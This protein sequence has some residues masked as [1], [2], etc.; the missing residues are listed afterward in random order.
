MRTSTITRRTAET[1]IR[2]TLDID[3]TGKSNHAYHIVNQRVR[4]LC[5][6][7][8]AAVLVVLT[9]L[10]HALAVIGLAEIHLLTYYVIAL[11]AVLLEKYG[12]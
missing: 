8:Y 3:G 10:G 2:L 11:K 9:H 6:L 7:L 12:L 5:H 1:D 4:C